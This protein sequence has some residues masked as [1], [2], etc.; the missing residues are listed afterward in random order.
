MILQHYVKDKYSDYIN[1]YIRTERKKNNLYYTIVYPVINRIHASV[2]YE[3]I[4]RAQAT[5][6]E[7]TSNIFKAYLNHRKLI[8]K[9]EGKSK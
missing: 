3:D 8:K 7:Y 9:W 5:D 1:Y 2:P 4:Q 6:M